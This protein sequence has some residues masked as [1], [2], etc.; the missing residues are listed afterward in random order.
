MQ[1]CY[2]YR[3]IINMAIQSRTIQSRIVTIQTIDDT[4]YI[5]F[6][7]IFPIYLM[8]ADVAYY[9]SKIKARNKVMSD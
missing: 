7:G 3:D 6:D 8:S 4:Q 9:L 2:S 5:L 1:R